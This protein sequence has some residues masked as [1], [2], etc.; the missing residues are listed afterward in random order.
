MHCNETFLLAASELVKKGFQQELCNMEAAKVEDGMEF[1]FNFKPQYYA[2]RPPYY[3][4][5]YRFQKHYYGSALIHDLRE[6]PLLVNGLK[7][8]CVH[9]Q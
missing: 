2:G 3:K 1:F 4:G 8:F 6:K 9:V 7:S 5:T